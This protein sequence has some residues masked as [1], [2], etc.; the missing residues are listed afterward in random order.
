LLLFSPVGAMLPLR[1][2]LS[3]RFLAQNSPIV[4]QSAQN[5]SKC[6]CW[7][8]SRDVRSP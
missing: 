6:S 1:R 5:P 8:L 2:A 3:W 4:Q 7:A